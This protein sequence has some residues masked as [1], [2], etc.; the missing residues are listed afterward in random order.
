MAFDYEAVRDI[1]VC[2]GSHARLVL[3][4]G[5][6]VSCDPETRLSYPIV[7]DIPCL[8]ADDASE[9]PAEVWSK[10]MSLHG[11]DPSTGK[12]ANGGE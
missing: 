1:L 11:R 2:P 9:L 10:V 4:E 3:E 5:L 7:D 6:L 12:P 8:L